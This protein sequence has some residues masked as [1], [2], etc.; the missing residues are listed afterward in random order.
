[1][2]L[3][4]MTHELGVGAKMADEVSVMYASQAL[5]HA[6]VITLFDACS[7]PYTQGLFASRPTLETH[8]GALKPIKG[9]V[10]PLRYYPE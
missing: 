9:T 5:E 1:M 8:R 7:H 6:D 2:A 3:L 4:L 10:P